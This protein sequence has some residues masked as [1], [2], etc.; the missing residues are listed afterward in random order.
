MILLTLFSL[1]TTLV[2]IWIGL[3]YKTKPKN[4]TRKSNT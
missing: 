2:G 4:G 3:K 1:L